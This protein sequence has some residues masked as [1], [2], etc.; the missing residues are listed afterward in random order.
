MAWTDEAKAGYS[1]TRP[2]QRNVTIKFKK[3]RQKMQKHHTKAN[4]RLK[5]M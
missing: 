5:A 2:D 1:E 4:K 3:K